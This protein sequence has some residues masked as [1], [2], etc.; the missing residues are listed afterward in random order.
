MRTAKFVRISALVFVTVV[1]SNDSLSQEADSG[2]DFIR[3][4]QEF[5]EEQSREFAR[6]SEDV[7]RM[8][9]R[10][11]FPDRQLRELASAA[12]RG[13]I[14]RIDRL[15]ADGVDVNSRG[16]GGAVP[17]FWAL[18]NIDGFERLLQHGADPHILFGYGDSVVHF[19]VWEKDSQF[20]ELLFEYGANPDV[21][22]V[23]EGETPLF[24][25]TDWQTK[26]KAPI[27][28]DAGADID[29]QDAR[30][31]TAIMVAAR[32]SQFDLVHLL[33]ERGAS[34]DI[35]NELD[36][37]LPDIIALVRPN[38]APENEQFL[39]METVIGWLNS[40]G[41]A[42]PERYVPPRDR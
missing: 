28:L 7:T 13:N 11:M 35:L 16:A 10:T 29:A 42:I 25:A 2:N 39:Y 21:R 23:S 27:L 33:L 24:W 1:L 30:G 17:L 31:D 19:A 4:L 22:N 3:E 32:L 14:D 41:V 40:R 5:I 36:N 15:V 38:I 26:N 6:A 12:G 18:R 9:L 37:A 20:L 34:Y 8:S